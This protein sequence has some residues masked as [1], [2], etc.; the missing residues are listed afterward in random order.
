MIGIN[1]DYIDSYIVNTDG[2][3]VEKDLH[4]Y[5]TDIENNNLIK[6]HMNIRS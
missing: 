2:N 3:L 6:L 4:E 5:L 1:S